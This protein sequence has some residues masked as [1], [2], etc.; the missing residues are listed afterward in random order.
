[1]GGV[2]SSS[3]TKNMR[4]IERIALGQDKGI[5]ICEICGHYYVIGIASQNIKILLELDAEFFQQQQSEKASFKDVLSQ[6]INN[7]KDK[8]Q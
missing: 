6:M 1:M 7:N 2:S 3:S 5:A 8:P 4:I